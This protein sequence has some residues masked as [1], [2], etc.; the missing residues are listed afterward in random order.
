MALVDAIHKQTSMGRPVGGCLVARLMATMPDEDRA[1]LEQAIA[2][3]LTS[4]LII[5]ALRDEG[6]RVGRDSFYAHRRGN[7]PCAKQ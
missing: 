5:R 7:C 3:D 6:Y 1:T 4:N 2:G